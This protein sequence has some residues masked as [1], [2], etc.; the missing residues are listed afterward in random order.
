MITID[1]ASAFINTIAI[2]KTS[3]FFSQQS[4]M[5]GVGGI[6]EFHEEHKHPLREGGLFM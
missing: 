5:F 6:N 1:N 2:T 3:D 4:G